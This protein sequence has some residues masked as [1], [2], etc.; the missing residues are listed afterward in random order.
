MELTL[1]FFSFFRKL[2]QNLDEIILNFCV[3]ACKAISKFLG[4]QNW[5][6]N[7]SMGNFLKM[8]IKVELILD[9]FYGKLCKTLQKNNIDI[10]IFL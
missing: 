2:N 6:L 9:W 8:L 7:V 4:K 5:F 3:F 1:F 10:W